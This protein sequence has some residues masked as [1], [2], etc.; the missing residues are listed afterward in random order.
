MPP[1]NL[2]L[3]TLEVAVWPYIFNP[4]GTALAALVTQIYLGF[5]QVDRYT[6]MLPN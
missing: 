1:F 6:T 5:R 2:L 3:M 4:I